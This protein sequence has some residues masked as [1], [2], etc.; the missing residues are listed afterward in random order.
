MNSLSVLF[1]LFCLLYNFNFMD[2]IEADNFP[3]SSFLSTFIVNHGG[4]SDVYFVCCAH[5]QQK[6]DIIVT[7]PSPPSAL[8]DPGGLGHYYFPGVSLF[9]PTRWCLLPW[10]VFI[11]SL[12]CPFTCISLCKF[13]FCPCCLRVCRHYH[14]TFVAK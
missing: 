2:I 10:D 8:G 13:S 7:P 11:S 5:L 12:L 1:S 3:F 4:L 6:K 9:S 14:W